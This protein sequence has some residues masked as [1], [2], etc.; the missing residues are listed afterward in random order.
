MLIETSLRTHLDQLSE[1]CLSPVTLA[2]IAQIQQQHYQGR[3]TAESVQAFCH[4]FALSPIQLG[5]ACLPIAAC[6]A[7]TPISNFNVGA[8]AI[9]RSGAFYFGANQEFAD[10]AM[11]Q[12][13]HAEQSAISHTWIAGETAITDMI[14]NATPCGHCRQFM[15]ELN[16]AEHLYIHLP[17]S[18]DNLLHQYLPDAFGPK[19]LNMAGALLDET[20]QKLSGVE[21]DELVQAAILAAEKSYAPYSKAF[22]G[23]ALWVGEQIITG[24]YAENAAFN[25]SFLPLQSAL[26]YLHFSGLEKT[27][28]KRI[29][30]AEKEA[31]LSHRAMTQMLCETYLNLPLEYIGL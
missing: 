23:V 28:I 3:L 1:Q 24:R 19:D 29:V 2:I 20:Q 27:Q 26:N 15:N 13:V 14:V 25:P 4:T 30:M 5:L 11:Q 16:S 31:G 18:Q 17:H 22:S 10:V 21:G 8:V 12:T 7:L 9:G 6:Y